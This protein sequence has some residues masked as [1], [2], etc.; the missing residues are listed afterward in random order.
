MHRDLP[1]AAESSHEAFNRLAMSGQVQTS[2]RRCRAVNKRG[3]P[4]AAPALKDAELCLAHAG[5]TKLDA[6]KAA[7]KSAE[8]RRQRAIVRS[9][10]LR[11][12][13]ARKLEEHADEVVN[14]YLRAIRSDDEAVA[15]RAAEAWLSRVYGRP[16]ET[17]ET[18]VATPDP[19]DVAKMT[20]EE[21]N[22]L[23]RRLIA[24][25]PDIAEQVLGLR[26][27]RDNGDASD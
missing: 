22:A 18:S 20:T 13:L 1:P 6:R 9:E 5:R 12:K 4:C 17:I 16:K 21:R 10:S 3:K 7:Q 14:A 2:V 25:H 19:L 11:D 24:Q 15:Y 26:V 8:V 27:V 23:K